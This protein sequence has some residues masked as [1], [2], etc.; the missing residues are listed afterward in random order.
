MVYFGKKQ[1]DD[2]TEKIEQIE[3]ELTGVVY[4]NNTDN[5][6]I[7]LNTNANRHFRFIKK[8]TGSSYRNW[9]K[10]GLFWKRD[11]ETE[12]DIFTVEMRADSDSATEGRG[13][14]ITC[15]GN[16]LRFVN[17]TKVANIAAPTADNHAVNMGYV[18]N[19]IKQKTITLSSAQFKNKINSN[20]TKVYGFTSNLSTAQKQN[21]LG[22]QLFTNQN[23]NPNGTNSYNVDYAYYPDA[24]E[25]KVFIT[26]IDGQAIND[27]ELDAYTIKIRYAKLINEA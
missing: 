14:H 8:T 19:F 18:D 2:N 11:N 7:S 21:I 9:T 12:V 4:K 1:T 25:L 23:W 22:V 24:Q 3:Q 26:R 17:A 5:L 10:W 13:A 6:D 20:K 27:T 16:M 15:E